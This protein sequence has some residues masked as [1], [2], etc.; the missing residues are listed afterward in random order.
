MGESGA[1]LGVVDAR[2]LLVP[3]ESFGVAPVEGGCGPAVV[4]VVPA[5]GADD[6]ALD[7]SLTVHLSS[8]IVA[9]S[10]Q[11]MVKDHNGI[12]V[13]GESSLEPMDRTFRFVPSSG[14]APGSRYS[15]AL[16]GCSDRT[17]RVIETYWWH[18]TTIGEPL[19]D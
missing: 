10:A 4:G 2:V 9:G 15:A 17:G 6:V 11:F 12:E 7:T 5:P 13:I 18:F 3:I 16:W 1:G 8:E 19:G 14:L